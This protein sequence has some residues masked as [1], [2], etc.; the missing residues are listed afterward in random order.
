[1]LLTTGR[2]AGGD[3]FM[4]AFT[5][6]SFA[7][8]VRFFFRAKRDGVLVLHVPAVFRLL[9][10]FWV[11]C[12]TAFGFLVPG[13]IVSRLRVHGSFLKM[14]FLF[15]NFFGSEFALFFVFGLFDFGSRKFF[16]RRTS[17]RFFVLC[18]HKLCGERT[19]LR[20][21]QRRCPVLCGLCRDF[22]VVVRFLRGGRVL[23]CFGNGL[24]DGR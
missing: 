17:L 14:L 11:I 23:L 6:G 20:V 13:F 18:F 9:P 22:I 3:G 1:M 24:F 16:F 12:F 7:G 21:T 10:G 2:F 19:K 5:F 4:L 15:M 8:F